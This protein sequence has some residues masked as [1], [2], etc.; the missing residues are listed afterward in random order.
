MENGSEDRAGAFRAVRTRFDR[1]NAQSVERERFGMYF[2]RVFACAY[3]LTNDETAAKNIVSEVF[4]HVL[5]RSSDVS[6]EEFVVELFGMTRDLVRTSRIL[7]TEGNGRL[8][9]RERELL[10]FLFDARLT[11]E[12]V[13]RLMR[14]T[15]QALSAALLGA[16]RKLQGGA[17][18]ATAS[19]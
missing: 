3:S 15:E 19:A 10:A 5:A 4:S 7:G 6:E 16:M 9:S 11:H 14:T 8:T 18:S 1:F 17:R 12:E 13:R 2:P